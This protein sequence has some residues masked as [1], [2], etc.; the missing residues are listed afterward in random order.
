MKR[1][2]IAAVLLFSCF[3]ILSCGK[4][5]KQEPQAEEQ[6]SRADDASLAETFVTINGEKLTNGDFRDFISYS[7][8]MMDPENRDNRAVM[9]YLKKDFVRHRLLLQAAKKEGAKIDE[10]KLNTML[11]AFKNEQGEQT[12]AEMQKQYDLDFSKIED[13]LRQRVLVTE[14]L[15][16]KTGSTEVSD[17]EIKAYY[18]KRKSELSDVTLAHIYHIVTADEKKAK[19]A[20]VMMNKGISFEEV[21]QKYSI[22]PEGEQGGDL[23]YIDI[24]TYPDIFSEAL[25]LKKGEVSG[26]LKSEF[27]YHIFKLIDVKDKVSSYDYYKA[28][29]K[30]ELYEIKEENKIKDYIDGLYQKSKIV[31]ADSSSGDSDSK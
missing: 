3:M 14:F 1:I 22:A 29:L 8:A 9:E 25:K 2:F 6:S 21:A 28:Q 12:I 16:K 10:K 13:I 5:E 20:L 18:E 27:G 31:Y 11:E 4:K 30:E 19:E 15:N 26:V 17:K 7:Y 23:G 24:S